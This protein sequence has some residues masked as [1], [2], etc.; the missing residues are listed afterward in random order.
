MAYATV[1]Q[2]KNELDIP[3]A[4]TADDG[5]ISNYIEAAQAAI[6]IKTGYTFEAAADTTR[7]FDANSIDSGGCVDGR[8]LI[9]GPGNPLA[10]ITSITNGDGTTVTSGQYVTEPRRIATYCYEIHIRS[11]A[12]I[13]WTYTDY[14]E[15]A[16]A[17]V[18]RWA[19]SITPAANVQHA[20]TKIAAFK[21][22][23]RD[24]GSSTF[25][26]QPGA[27][28]PQSEDDFI[29][30]ACANLPRRLT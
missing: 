18:G 30:A 14:W 11:D 19:Y 4:T 6:D 24:F 7:Y 2:V 13:S 26:T 20:C 17:I 9:L 23:E 29:T 15:N 28:T 3:N 1:H 5:L 25:V 8:K 22:R 10:A 16:I 21:Y 12:A 27:A